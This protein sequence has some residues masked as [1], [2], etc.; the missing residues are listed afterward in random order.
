MR[1]IQEPIV[2]PP[3]LR[4]GARVALVAPAGPIDAARLAQATAVCEQLGLVAVPGASAL[5]RTGFLAG[6]DEDRASD[7]Q[8]AIDDPAI[9]A[10]WTLRGG[11]GTVRLLPRLELRAMRDN[12]K[13]YIGFSDN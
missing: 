9:D 7:L 8:R 12:P 11:Y 4:A 13:A 3:A 10:I 6:S 2:K 1:T 5:S